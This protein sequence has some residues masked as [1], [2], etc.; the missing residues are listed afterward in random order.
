MDFKN[1]LDLK[2]SPRA[3]WEKTNLF[4]LLFR[5]NGLM[6][7]MTVYVSVV[8]I[9]PRVLGALSTTQSNFRFR[10][11]VAGVGI[12]E[13]MALGNDGFAV[14]ERDNQGGRMLGLNESTVLLHPRI[15]SCPKKKESITLR[16]WKKNWF[17]T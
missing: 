5:E 6:T 12:S 9:P 17:V 15:F 16:W 8:T 3:E 4:L 7:W 13:I 2:G 10:P 14:I 11:M 1:D